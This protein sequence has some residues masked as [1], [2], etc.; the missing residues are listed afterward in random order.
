MIL[1]CFLE[2]G[3]LKE[4]GPRLRKTYPETQI[5]FFFDFLSV[6]QWPRTEAED[7]IF[8][9]AMKHMNSVYVH[10]DLVLFIETEL[11]KVDETLHMRRFESP[12]TSGRSS[13]IRFKL[14]VRRIQM[15]DHSSMIVLSSVMRNRFTSVD[16]LKI[17]TSTHLVSYLKRPFGRPNTIINDDRGWLFLERI[18]IAIKAATAGAH[19]FDDIVLSNDEKLRTQ[20]YKWMRMLL[21]AAKE[22][23]ELRRTLEHFDG[24]LKTKRFSFQSDEGTVRTLMTELVENFTENWQEE[25]VKQESSSKR[26][27]EILLRWGEFSNEY[28]KEARLLKQENEESGWMW[29]SLGKLVGLSIIGPMI[30]MLPFVLKVTDDCVESL[31]GHSVWIG[32]TIFFSR[33]FSTHSFFVHSINMT[34][35]YSCWFCACS[36]GK[37]SVELRI[38]FCSSW[39]AYTSILLVLCC[40]KWFSYISVSTC[41]E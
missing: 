33:F 7:K 20:V 31:V 1:I 27:R 24:I 30:A 25:V 28:V 39:M 2:L 19:R 8:R 34:Y 40:F 9:V 36:F 17:F 4:F 5:L 11:P 32:G 38:S 3:L 23:S 15:M 22:K 10:C 21:R 35:S 41:I 14:R 18:T 6:P 29:W 26:L 16:D 12:T 37:S 13:W